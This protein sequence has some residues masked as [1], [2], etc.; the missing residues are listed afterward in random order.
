GRRNQ[1]RRR[2]RDDPR[3][4]PAHMDAA[5]AV[6]AAP[7]AVTDADMTHPDMT[8]PHVADANGAH[9]DMAHPYAAAHAHAAAAVHAAAAETAAAAEAAGIGRGGRGDQAGGAKRGNRGD[10]ENR[11][12]NLGKHGSLL[13]LSR[14]GELIGSAIG[15]PLPRSRFINARENPFCRPGACHPRHVHLT[16]TSGGLGCPARRVVAG[17]PR[18]IATWNYRLPNDLIACTAS[19]DKHL[20]A[21]G[22]ND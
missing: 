18:R 4:V 2:N 8:D 9:A 20:T 14:W 13:G 19:R 5:A 11:S 17:K 10:G 15:R 21:A 22:L 16:E 7:V 6:V 1:A 3:T 12:T